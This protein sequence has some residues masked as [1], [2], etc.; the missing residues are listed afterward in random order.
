VGHR[1][2]LFLRQPKSTREFV[3]ALRAK[4]SH[5]RNETPPD[6]SHI[7]KQNEPGNCLPTRHRVQIPVEYTTVNRC[8]FAETCAKFTQL[9][10][11]SVMV[12]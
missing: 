11:L 10:S 3:G 5:L 2:P 8:V 1:L 12:S 7:G 4:G 6:G 9:G